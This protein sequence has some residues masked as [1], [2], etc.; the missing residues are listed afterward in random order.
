[1]KKQAVLCGLLHQG[2]GGMPQRSARASV[3]I[4]FQP[5]NPTRDVATVGLAIGFYR[6]NSDALRSFARKRL[7]GIGVANPF[8]SCTD[9]QQRF[10]LDVND[11]LVRRQP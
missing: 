6:G 3:A 11:A 8:Q 4:W 10:F 1:Q 9:E 5:G 2:G 7:D